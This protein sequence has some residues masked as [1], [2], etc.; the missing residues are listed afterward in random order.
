MKRRYEGMFLIDSAA[1]HEWAA[2]DAEVRRLLERIAADAEVCVKFD[3][4]R[5]AYPIKDRRRGLYVLT[6]FQSEPDKIA[7]LER[8][9]RLS[10]LVLRLL[11]VS[12]AEVTDARIAELQ[13]HTADQS[14]VPGSDGRRGDERGPRRDYGRDRPRRRG[15]YDEG[16]GGREGFEGRTAEARD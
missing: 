13:K 2:A 10:D 16:H 1:C 8:D 15:E 4:R 6:Y 9:A 12:G 3:E 7:T 5:L 14:L 11:V